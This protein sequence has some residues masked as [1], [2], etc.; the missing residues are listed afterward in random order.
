[1][2]K[3]LIYTTPLAVVVTAY[4]VTAPYWNKHYDAMNAPEPASAGSIVSSSSATDTGTAFDA[5]ADNPIDVRPH[6][7]YAIYRKK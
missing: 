5:I 3:Y 1:M 4:A 2:R 7:L 6:K